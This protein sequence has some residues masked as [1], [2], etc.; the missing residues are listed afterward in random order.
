[1]YKEIKMK[2]DV[3]LLI[4]CSFTTSVSVDSKIQNYDLIQNKI[5]EMEEK[6]DE[7]DFDSDMLVEAKILRYF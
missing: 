6:K 5:V 7:V 1:M 3:I 4:L 2:F